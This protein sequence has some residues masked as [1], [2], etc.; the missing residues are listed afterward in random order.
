MVGSVFEG[1]VFL[2]YLGSKGEIV[3]EI[4]FFF[5]L[6]FVMVGEFLK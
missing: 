5:R 6:F 4:D 1:C 3:V 2:K